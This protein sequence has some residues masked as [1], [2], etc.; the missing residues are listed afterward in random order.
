MAKLKWTAEI[1]VDETWVADG[2]DLTAERLKEMVTSDLQ[3]A[4]GHEIACRIVKAPDP[5]AIRKLQE[6][7]EEETVAEQRQRAESAV[8]PVSKYLTVLLLVLS[9]CASASAATE[10]YTTRL[11]DKFGTYQGRLVVR[12]GETKFYGAS[13]TYEGRASLSG[14]TTKFYD[15]SGTL[16]GSAKK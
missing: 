12:K 4:Y 15:K 3:W 8:S 10:A 2:F 11:Y 5:A 6:G 1:E 7:Y 13:G 9:F 16:K 14:G